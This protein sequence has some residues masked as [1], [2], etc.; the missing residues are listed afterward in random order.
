[1]Q[2]QLIKLEEPLR[3][4]P[5]NRMVWILG[6]VFSL[7]K[8]LSFNSPTPFVHSVQ[9]PNISANEGQK[10]QKALGL[11]VGSKLDLKRI[12]QNIRELVQ[13]GKIQSLFIRKQESPQGLDLILDVNLVERLKDLDLSEV[14]PDI[15]SEISSSAELLEPDKVIEPRN[16]SNLKQAIRTAY[17]AR[18]FFFVEVDIKKEKKIDSDLVGLK[19]SVIEGMPTRIS[20]IKLGNVDKEQAAEFRRAINLKVGEPF[21]R[22]ALEKS[23]NS[24]NEY[25]ISNQYP[26]SKVDETNL[27]FNETKSRVEIEF[28]LKVG[29]KY[30]FVFNGNSLFPS[31]VIRQWITPDVLGQ[32][33][34]IRYIQQLILERYK[35][36]GYHFCE[37]SWTAEKNNAGKVQIYK[38]AIDEGSRVVIDSLIVNGA[39]EIGVSRFK[40]LFFEH[41]SG[42]L[43]RGVFWE[44]GLEQTCKDMI[45]WLEED[46]YLRVSLPVPRVSFS[47]DKKGVDLIFNVELGT[48]TVVSRIDLN[49]VGSARRKD[50]EAL[51]LFQVGEPVKKSLIDRSKELIEQFYLREGFSDVKVQRDNGIVYGEDP[52]RAIVRISVDEGIQYFV[53]NVTVEGNRVTKTEVIERDIRVKPGEKYDAEKIRQSEDELLLTG[54]FSKVEMIGTVDPIDNNKKNLK[55]AVL[56]TKAGSGELGLGAVY[57]DPRF[58]L[59]GFLGVAYNNM[60]GLNQTAS[61]RTEIGL[62]LTSKLELVP[63]VEY[64]AV[65]GYRA[66]YL[67]N[68]PAVFFSQASLD[69]YEVGTNS[70][71]TISNLQSRARIEERVEKKFSQVF[72]FIYRFHR[73]ER[74]TTKTLVLMDANDPNNPTNPNGNNYQ[75][76]FPPA[77][78]TVNIGST[79]P[80]FQLDF[81]DDPFNPTK[82]TF[83]TLDG[84]LAL[85]ALASSREVSFHM[86][87]LR[88][89]FYVPLFDP[90]GLALFAG[91]GYADSLDHQYPIPKARLLTELS[92]GGQGS[93]RGFSPRRFNPQV[94]SVTAGFYNLRGELRT[95][96]FGDLSLAVFVDSGQIFSKLAAQS[97]F[98]DNR[99]DGVGV[100]LRYKTPVGPAVIDISQGLGKDREVIKFNFTIGVF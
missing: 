50:I 52:S 13:G 70:G 1:M 48:Q 63:F 72:R 36:A 74:T 81:R 82:G 94:N 8:A 98:T 65:L 31:D 43:S 99:H 11:E 80:G 47:N 88:N 75:P 55:V 17:E 35:A 85:P 10:I 77:T 14:R 28:V 23:I 64:S 62:P 29:K 3:T 73:Y 44:A 56:E 69:N 78:E 12:D 76:G 37:V 46:G 89:S 53:G 16:M 27:N 30:Q 5:L 90:F 2:A 39:S 26:D 21:T 96:V 6:I 32:S 49:G 7:N 25:F 33:D 61:A 71:G 66:P 97:W 19:V 100:G 95:E 24:L 41:G 58:R 86:W 38:F 42:V 18:G 67:L 4:M 51:I 93:I 54:L 60:F 59:R 91:A 15:Q 79:G 87:M 83:H 57:E 9:I 68:V 22:K 20:R 92:L 34:P 84:E 45:S 40:K